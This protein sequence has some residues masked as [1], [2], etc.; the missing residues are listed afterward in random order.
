MANIP[1][2]CHNLPGKY[3]M[4]GS[5][6]I[7]Q[8]CQLMI[9]KRK[10]KVSKGKAPNFMAFKHPFEYCSSLY[11]GSRQNWEQQYTRGNIEHWSKDTTTPS[12]FEFE[13][14]GTQYNL[15]I[16]PQTSTAIIS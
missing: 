11:P 2:K 8:D 10:G 16:D 14:Q 7:K 15:Q 5:Q 1:N 4:K 13:Y 6:L 12:K 3:V 9:L